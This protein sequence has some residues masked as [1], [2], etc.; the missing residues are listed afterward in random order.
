MIAYSSLSDQ[1][2]AGLLR[3]GDQAAFAQI[4]ER[5]W[6]IIYAHVYKM[7]LDEEDAKDIVQ[8]V[9]SEIWLKR[10]TGDY[11]NL[12]GY[13]YV[14]AR[15]KVLNAIKKS[16]YR[17]AYL[18][19]LS[20]YAADFSNATLEQ[21]QEKDMAAAIER[22]IQALPPRMREVFQLSRKENLS[23]KEIA[24]RLGTSPKTVKKQMFKSLEQIRT[25]LK[26]SGTIA[27]LMLAC[28]R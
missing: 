18:D 1:Q 28:L 16:K 26:D 22:E 6:R 13:L 14:A 9:F 20:R 11:T 23:Y 25:N 15:N 7:L 4:Y 10:E 3:T 8:E 27:L 19:S 17:S 2:L 12:G 24:E 5:H 21:L